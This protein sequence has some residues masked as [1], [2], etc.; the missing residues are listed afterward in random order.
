[1]TLALG[2]A[3][4]TAGAA[5]G[6]ATLAKKSERDEICPEERCTSRRGVELDEEL[7]TYA[8]ASTVMFAVGGSA[9]VASLALFLAEEPWKPAA[10]TWLV[11]SLGPNTGGL[12]ISGS[13]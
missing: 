9:L 12:T 11:P 8:T 6:G 2:S 10:T 5:L 4:V 13:F 3:G 1:V 7:R